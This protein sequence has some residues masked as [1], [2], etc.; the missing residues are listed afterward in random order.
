MRAA[1]LASAVRGLA[2]GANRGEEFGRDPA[3]RRFAGRHPLRGLWTEDV[4]VAEQGDPHPP[5]VEI[6]SQLLELPG[7]PADLRDGDIGAGRDFLLELHVL[8]HAV[9][10]GVLEGRDGDRDVKG[11]AAASSLVDQAD[12]LDRV[13]IEHRGL[14]GGARVV[15][16][17]REDVFEVERVHVVQG[18]GELAAVLADARQVNV[19][20]QAARA[21]GRGDPQRIVTDRS[22]RVAGDAAGD[23]GG[24]PRQPRRHLQ[25]ARLTSQCRGDE[26]HD[27]AE[28]ARR[29]GV[30]ERVGHLPSSRRTS[31]AP[32]TMAWSLA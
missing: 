5:I 1:R 14:V 7:V 26:L 9:G 30:A 11:V 24:D 3:P 22:A 19:G 27:V 2:L 13:E 29:Q 15:A 20:R 18:L 31:R 6:A 8:I 21:R 17:Q 4:D 12:E 23:D 10:L 28:A 16:G 32:S 25:Q